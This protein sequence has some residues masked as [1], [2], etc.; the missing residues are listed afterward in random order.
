MDPELLIM[1][2]PRA[3]DAEF[4]ANAAADSAAFGDVVAPRPGEAPRR[5]HGSAAAAMASAAM[6]LP[7]GTRPPRERK[8]ASAVEAAPQPK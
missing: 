8:P 6:A 3:I 7:A 5:S 4:A 1:P 2:K